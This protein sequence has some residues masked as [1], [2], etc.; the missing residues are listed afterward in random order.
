MQL[1]HIFII[2][3]PHRKD[4]LNLIT[5]QLDSFGLEYEVFNGVNGKKI[6]AKYE[7]D[8]GNVGCTASHG[9]VLE[10]AKIMGLSNCLV[11]EDDCELSNDFLQIITNLQLPNNWDLC[12]LSGTHREQPIKVNDTIS[13]CVRTLTTHAYLINVKSNACDELIMSLS[14]FSGTECG[15]LCLDVS[16]NQPVDCYFATLQKFNYFY[17]LNK[18]IAWQKGGYSDI[19]GREM[20]YEWLKKEIKCFTIDL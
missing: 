12:Y 2:T 19:N 17:V 20:N 3:L 13:R 9:Q 14:I 11:L 6:K 7:S 5:S 18:P 10:R 4:R 16:F 8:N 15:N 1:E